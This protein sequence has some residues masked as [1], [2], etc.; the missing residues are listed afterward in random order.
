MDQQLL[1]RPRWRDSGGSARAAEG[2]RGA[3]KGSQRNPT[4]L[5]RILE[6]GHRDIGFDALFSLKV[7]IA[8]EFALLRCGEGFLFAGLFGHASDRWLD[9]VRRVNWVRHG[10]GS[11]PLISDLGTRS[12]QLCIWASG[13]AAR[14]GRGTQG[15][16]ARSQPGRSAYV[17]RGGESLALNSV[18]LP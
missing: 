17:G 15:K 5:Q 16:K 8:G 14:R 12:K 6:Q 11:F 2:F 7:A 1:V 9:M 3:R 13:D 10:W 4:Y 18:S